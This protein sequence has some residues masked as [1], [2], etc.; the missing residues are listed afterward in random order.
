MA[1]AKVHPVVVQIPSPFPYKSDKVVPWK[2]GISVLN[3]DSSEKQENEATDI[4]K[5]V[6]ITFLGLEE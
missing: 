3:N 2:Y 1:P 6:W 4:G 5:I